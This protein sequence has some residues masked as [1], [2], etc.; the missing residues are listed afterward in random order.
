MVPELQ[1]NNYLYVPNFLPAQ[2]AEDL[3]QWMYKQENC[4]GLIKDERESLNVFGRAVKD[5][6]PFVKLLVD[7]IP[8][9]S[10]LCG[11]KVLPTYVYSIIYKTNSELIR[12]TDRD[13][14]EI[15]VTL[16]LQKDQNWPICIKKPTGE[17]VAIELN[18]GD[19]VLYLGCV[20]E[21]WRP[22][23][24][25]GQNFVQTFLHYARADG[26]CAYTFFDKKQFK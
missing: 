4:G 9:V 26:P 16:N 23:K 25:T 17:E 20:A 15:S 21:H 11:E 6:L 19:A 8:Q 24:F 1:F 18:P 7:K 3:A 5:A 10:E 14:C 2:E 12:H 13:S 22:G